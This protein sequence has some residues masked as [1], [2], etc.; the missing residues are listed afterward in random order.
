VTESTDLF[1]PLGPESRNVLA[2]DFEEQLVR[3]GRDLG[4]L[5]VVRN[6]DVILRPGQPSRGIDVLWAIDNPWTGRTEGWVGEGK[7]RK[8][9]T[10]YTPADVKKEIQILRD[11]VGGLRDNARFYDDEHVKRAK[12]KELLG[13]IIAYRSED[14]DLDKLRTTLRDMD[15]ERREEDARPTRITFLSPLT[16]EGLADCFNVVGRP[17]RS[18]WSQSAQHKAHWTRVCPPHQLGVGLIAYRTDESPS[19]K[20]IWARGNLEERDIEGWSQVVYDW[21]ES[22]DVIAFTDMTEDM[23]KRID[24]SW[25]RVAA[26]T[27][28]RPKGRLPLELV[29]LHTQDGMKQ[30][31]RS[32]PAVG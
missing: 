12:I 6:V 4:W 8:D 28:T 32:W 21:G 23:R 13:G 16:L 2:E 11:K 14:F 15:F 26:D 10:K 24:T 25:Q 31:D 3:M 9:K 22:F 1:D 27:K 20:V 7:R 18:L 19:R 17:R 5:E 30:F 29:P